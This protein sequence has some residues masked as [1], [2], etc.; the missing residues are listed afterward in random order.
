MP[1]QIIALIL[2][3]LVSISANAA[4]LSSSDTLLTVPYVFYVL[5]PALLIHLV[6]TV[7]C[8]KQGYYRSNSFTIKHLIVAML[9][10]I[11]GIALITFEYLTNSTVASLHIG[12]YLSIVFVYVFMSLFFMLPYFL[13]LV[14]DKK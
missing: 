4:D 10:P 8:Q 14:A 9:V 1:N 5:V 13:N 6:A 12:T 11:I 7:Y 3:S 2:L